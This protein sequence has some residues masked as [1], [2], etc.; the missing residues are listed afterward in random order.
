MKRR[1]LAGTVRGL[2]A[3]FPAVALVGPRQAGKTT[4]AKSLG[5]RYYDLEDEGI[6][7][8]VDA[9]WDSI[10]GSRSLVI[11]DEAQSHPPIFTR[12][13]GAI[14]T[15]RKRNGRFLL[16]GSVSPALMRSVSESLAG[17]L[18]VAELTPFILP[19][20]R[21]ALLDRLW[22]AGGYPDGGILKPSAYP[23]WQEQYIR[24][25]VQRDLPEWG[26]SARPGL[27]HRLI[28]MLA[29]VHGQVW[30]A[31]GIGRSLGVSYHT[32]DGYLDSLEGAF[33]VRKLPAYSANIRKRL[34]KSPKVYWRDSGVLHSL[35]GLGRTAPLASRPWAGASWEGF[36]IE[37][38]AGFL[39]SRGA[40]F[41]TSFLR[42]K[43]GEEIDLVLEKNGKLWAV[44]IK[45]SARPSEQDFASLNA[46]ADLIGA[47]F[48]VLVS[49]FPGLHGSGGRWMSDLPGLLGLLGK[50]DA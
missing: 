21:P 50:N 4:M 43:D 42:T 1:M 39:Q 45:L 34:V 30:N 14:D 8:A 33:Q 13:R 3:R 29:V 40:G 24:T 16:L 31:S 44:E 41:E 12:L 17:R 35:L 36:V 37:Q 26:L 20:V 47:D 6:R 5:R 38:A 23:L 46:K 19:E 27:T 11:F 2:L 48:R 28:R 22:R 10:A 25:L 7:A 18:A 32:V 49:R 9:E 15:D